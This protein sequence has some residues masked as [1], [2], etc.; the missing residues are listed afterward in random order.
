M[1][2][3]VSSPAP[4]IVLHGADRGVKGRFGRLARLWLAAFAVLGGLGLAACSASEGGAEQNGIAGRGDAGA[5]APVSAARGQRLLAQ[6]QCGSCHAIPEVP[7]TRRLHGPSLE[8]FGKR[9]YIAGHLPNR[10]DT[11]AQWIM[12]PQ[13]LVPD[14]PMPNMGVSTADARDMASYLGALQ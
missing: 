13:S 6:Y 10:S 3:A 12:S 11:L 4:F 9:S 5:G 7:A 1:P 8:A 14:S 2:P